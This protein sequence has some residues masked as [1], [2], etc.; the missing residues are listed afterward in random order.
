MNFLLVNFHDF[1]PVGIVEIINYIVTT[2]L[3][4]FVAYRVVFVIIGFFAVKHYKKAKTEHSYAFL[5]AARNEEK[6]IGNLIDSIYQSN[7]PMDKIKIFVIADNCTDGTAQLCRNKG[8]IVYERSNK[9]EIGKGYAL[10]VL[11]DHIK[12]D[13][14]IDAFEGYFVF[15]ADNLIHPNFIAEMNNAFD[16]GAKMITSYR[17]TKNFS[18]NFISA[19]YGYHQYRNMRSLHIPRT[20][21]GL[22]CTVTGTGFLVA[23]EIL[24]NGWK[25]KLITEDAELSADKIIEGYQ[26]TY[27]HDAIFYDEQ[28]ETF[29]IM[30]RQRIRWA[31]GGMLVFVSHAKRLLRSMFKRRKTLKA[32][33]K[34]SQSPAQRRFTFYDIFFQLF[35]YALV[36]CFWAI[37]YNIALI[38]TTPLSGL[39][40]AMCFKQIGMGMLKS[41]LMLY[42]SC[43]IQILPVVFCEWKRIN[44]K[45]W[46]KILYMFTFPL[47]DLFNLPIMVIAL[48]TKVEWKVIPHTAQI[49]IEEIV[50][51]KNDVSA[52]QT[53]EQTTEEKIEESNEATAQES[54]DTIGST[55]NVNE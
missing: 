31:K 24:R 35:P 47:F 50:G 17:N 55:A 23:N 13:Y 15:D 51:N 49:K 25:W 27:V 29:K 12:E 54:L 32:E 30:F 22:S 16:S 20:A 40:V 21:L 53:S 37:I 6:V 48:F 39:S 8:A 9:K 43:F 26:I 42:F 18:K 3:A 5:I 44:A 52:N 10:N 33:A 2:L 11:V 38:I 34:S 19:S 7:Y 41:F 46:Q 4:I 28:P 1:S 36:T 14:G 45:V